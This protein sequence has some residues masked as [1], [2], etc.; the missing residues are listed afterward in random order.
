[1][2]RNTGTVWNKA[3]SAAEPQRTSSQNMCLS[4]NPTNKTLEDL[5]Q[6]SPT[7]PKEARNFL[8]CKGLLV[9][10]GQNVNM[11]RTVSCLYQIANIPPSGSPRQVVITI[12]SLTLLLE[13]SETGIVT[14]TYQDGFQAK[15]NVELHLENPATNRGC[16]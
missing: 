15:L 10:E 6:S 2:S 14:Q 4:S 5:P 11:N 7:D 1:M 13:T 12:R 9:P 16:P 3:S 8:E